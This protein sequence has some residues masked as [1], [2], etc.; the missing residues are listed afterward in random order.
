MR[1]IGVEQPRSYKTFLKTTYST[2]YQI[3]GFT[4]KKQFMKLFAQAPAS[5]PKA[6]LTEKDTRRNFLENMRSKAKALRSTLA[7]QDV[8]IRP[9]DPAPGAN[10][11]GQ[12]AIAGS[13]SDIIPGQANPKPSQAKPKPSQAYPDLCQVR[14]LQSP[15]RL[16]LFHLPLQS[17][18]RPQKRKP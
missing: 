12:Q 7:I 6:P 11:P 17:P 13:S 16:N 18:Y 9:A 4:S 1:S 14:L 8:P 15:V 10:A 2:G 5:D 3:I